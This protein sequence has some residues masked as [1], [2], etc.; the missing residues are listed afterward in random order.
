VP[1]E[2]NASGEWENSMIN[3]HL[4]QRFA[5]PLNEKQVEIFDEFY[6]RREQ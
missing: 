6:T 2:R 4:P 3:K 5:Q 1:A